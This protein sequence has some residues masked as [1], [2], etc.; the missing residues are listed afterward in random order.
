MG[1]GKENTEIVLFNTDDGKI[2]IDVLFEEE[3]VWLSQEQMSQ[4]FEKG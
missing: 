1:A 3:S 2:K 4:L